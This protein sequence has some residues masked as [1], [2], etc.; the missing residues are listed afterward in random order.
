M[1]PAKP[2]PVEQIVKVQAP[3]FPRRGALPVLVYDR[4]QRH[5]AQQAL[6]AA[7]KRALGRDPKGYFKA[8]WIAAD[9]LWQIG[10]R[11]EAQPW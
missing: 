1:T 5:V 8:R 9:G 2:A 3:L 7:T 4:K 10:E 11:V 6:S